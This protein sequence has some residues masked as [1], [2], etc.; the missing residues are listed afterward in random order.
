MAQFADARAM[1]STSPKDADPPPVV[2]RSHFLSQACPEPTPAFGAF[3]RLDYGAGG[4]WASML[5]N[6]SKI[7]VTDS[8]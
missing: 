1:N 5:L 6:S 2:W 7:D 8:Q 3:G 4:E